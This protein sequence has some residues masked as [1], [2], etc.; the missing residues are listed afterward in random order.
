MDADGD[1]AAPGAP[2]KAPAEG[3]PSDAAATA[4]A[5]AAP[6]AAAAAPAP[7][8]LSPEDSRHRDALDTLARV[9][10]GAAP[11]SL[12]L[13]FMHSAAVA[14]SA[15]ST[16][17]L[18][19][20]QA[21]EPRNSVCHGA[22]VF[23]NAATHAGTTVD[24]FLRDNLDWLARATNWAKFSATAG[25]GVIHRGHVRAGRSLMAPYLPRGGGSGSGSSSSSSSP[26][27][28]GGALFALGLLGCGTTAPASP[29]AP[30]LLNAL[31][32]AAA[33][34]VQHG[35]AL[36]LGAAALGTAD[37]AASDELRGLLYADSAVGGEGAALALGLL[38]AGAGADLGGGAAGAP[39]PASAAAGPSSS[40]SA[41]AA[42]TP[43]STAA[44]ELLAYAHDTQHEKIIRACGVGAFNVFF[45]F[46]CF[47]ETSQ[48]LNEKKLTALSL[49]LSYLFSPLLKTPQAPPSARLA[50]ETSPPT[51]SSVSRPT[52]TRSSATAARSRRASRSRAPP[53]RPPSGGC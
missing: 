14:G 13:E 4:D 17:L 27:S 20:R 53:R 3:G 24:A 47:P 44:A 2:A 9:L 1:D 5:A 23:A 35:A 18:R 12:T 29:D 11:T 28:E 42:A 41:Q 39:A 51:S 37:A 15:D 34:P 32:G 43:R 49:F 50:R 48:R 22:V 38:H 26:F 8:P 25:L 30:F 33:E 40:S 21:V 36:G 19:A 7:P 10:S 46:F 31:R 16:A 52:R 6:A 45:S